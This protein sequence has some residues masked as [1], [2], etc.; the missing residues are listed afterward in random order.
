M[1]DAADPP[2]THPE[3]MRAGFD[4]TFGDLHVKGTARVTPAGL[5]CAGIAGV[6]V[7]LAAAALVR[8]ARR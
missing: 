6:A 4:L 1:T 3:E 5:I 2:L 7:M 8:A